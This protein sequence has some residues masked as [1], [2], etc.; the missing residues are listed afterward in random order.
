MADE[1]KISEKDQY[2]ALR[3]V[4]DALTSRSQNPETEREA[5]RLL[6]AGYL[7]RDHSGH[8]RLTERGKLVLRAGMRS[9]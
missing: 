1:E 5:Q 3:R 8:L 4:L 6:A 9:S 7:Y 2:V